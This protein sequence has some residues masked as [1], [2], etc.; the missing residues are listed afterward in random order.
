[1][2]YTRLPDGSCVST[3]SLP[4]PSD[5]WLYAPNTAGWDHERD[6]PLDTPLPVLGEIHRVAVRNA[7]RWAV[8]GAT[9]RGAEMD[10][11]PDALV[12]NVVYALCGPRQL[13][14]Q[15]HQ[16]EGNAS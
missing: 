16:T 5:H 11:D 15:S 13:A 8:R 12:Q 6:C 4:L 10:F 7:V 9:V 2:E 14:V 1:M 3:A